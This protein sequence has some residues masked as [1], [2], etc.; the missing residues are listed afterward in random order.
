MNNS[1]DKRTYQ[2]VITGH[3][4]SGKSAFVRAISTID[5]PIHGMWDAGEIDA[6]EVMLHL[7]VPP[8]S[9]RFDF[10]WEILAEGMLGFI[11]MID[12]RSPFTFRETQSIAATFAA[13]APTPY[14]YA[15]NFQD[16]PYA[17][18]VE[19]LRIA[20]RVP[21]EIPIIPCVATDKDSVKNVLLALCDEVLKDIAET[22]DE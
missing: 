8:G 3:W 20:L 13:Y 6:E 16:H 5:A 9:R 15:A 1:P 17:W 7:L 19:A 14:V 4:A 12:S 21:P 22:V 11:V 18:D 2:I 10:M